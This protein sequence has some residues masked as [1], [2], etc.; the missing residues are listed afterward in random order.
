MSVQWYLQRKKRIK[1]L[2]GTQSRG[3]SQ[4]KTGLVEAY[5]RTKI[6]PCGL[7]TYKGDFDGKG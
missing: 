7:Q 3:N 4:E 1:Y 6:T 2:I 5:E